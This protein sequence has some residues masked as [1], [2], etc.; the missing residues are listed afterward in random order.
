MKSSSWI[1]FNAF[2]QKCPPDKQKSLMAHL[3][4]ADRKLIESLPKTRED[5]SQ[6]AKDPIAEIH[7]SWFAPYLRSLPERD[8][9]LFFSALTPQQAEGL[10]KSLLFSGTGAAIGEP[11]KKFLQATLFQKISADQADL[12]PVS[13]LPDTPLFPLLEMN[14]ADLNTVIDYLGLHDLAVEMRQIIEKAKLD[15]IYKVLSS[16]EQ[17][18]L[19]I[20]M[21]SREPV[22]FSRMGLSNWRGDAESL[23]NMMRY[24]GLNRLAKAL[25]GQHPSFIWHLCHHMDTDK[26]VMLQ[27]LIAPLENAA[28]G[29]LLVS[30]IVELL[31]YK[32]SS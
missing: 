29:K 11:A 1:A 28:A 20:L 19:K 6:A 31:S 2:L 30:Q 24:R 12:L 27:K 15:N 4:E 8:I 16:E 18:Y 21:Q 22:A 32:G 26:A 5:P 25:H 9:R 3:P 7:F 23:K 13:F 10:K 14:L 17:S